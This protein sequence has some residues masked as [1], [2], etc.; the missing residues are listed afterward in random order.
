VQQDGQ[1][2]VDTVRLHGVHLLAVM[3]GFASVPSG[4]DGGSELNAEEESDGNTAE[5]T[6]NGQP[7]HDRES[8]EEL[9]INHLPAGFRCDI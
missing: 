4:N 9:H 6:D 5:N 2:S 8:A 3:V 7:D 1:Q